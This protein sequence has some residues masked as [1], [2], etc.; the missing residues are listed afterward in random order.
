MV[1]HLWFPRPLA[2]TVQRRVPASKPPSCGWMSHLAVCQTIAAAL[3]LRTLVLFLHSSQVVPGTT[4]PRLGLSL[5]RKAL[6]HTVSISI[7]STHGA[8]IVT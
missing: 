3:E 5:Q 4:V 6:L 8:R 7:Q 2:G 1:W